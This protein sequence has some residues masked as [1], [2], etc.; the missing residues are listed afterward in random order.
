VADGSVSRRTVIRSLLED[1]TA[2]PHARLCSAELEPK[3]R[4]S[5]LATVLA[6]RRPRPHAYV[7]A[8]DCSRLL[9]DPQLWKHGANGER[10]YTLVRVANAHEETSCGSFYFVD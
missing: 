1:M 10:T 8:Y 9:D 4:G 5:P 3:M 6:Q 2:F 7:F